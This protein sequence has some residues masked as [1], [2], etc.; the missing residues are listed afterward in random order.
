MTQQHDLPTVAAIANAA[1]ANGERPSLLLDRVLRA[2]E[3]DAR[4]NA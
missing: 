4:V 1:R 3:D 2:L